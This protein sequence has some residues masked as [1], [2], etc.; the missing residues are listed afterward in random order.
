MVSRLRASF[1]VSLQRCKGFRGL[2]ADGLFRGQDLSTYM[3]QTTVFFRAP[4]EYLETYFPPQ[5]NRS[6]PYSPFPASI[7]GIP[8]SLNPHQLN[9]PWRHEWPTHLVFF[10]DLLRQEGI[11]KLL[12]EKGYS[13]VWKGGRSW[14]GEGER[15]EGV[16][17]W[18]WSPHNA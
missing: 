13:E 8:H 1:R 4:R 14:E 3:D 18:R 7:P 16:K 5:V 15:K 6:F 12:E 17:V 10:G 9:Y 11:K 2:T